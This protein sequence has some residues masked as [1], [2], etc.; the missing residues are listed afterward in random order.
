MELILIRHGEPDVAAIEACGFTGTGRNF[1]PLSERGIL[2]AEAV[3]HDSMLQGAALIVS[4]PYTRALQTAAVIAHS[5][6]LRI[7]V[8]PALHEWLP[9]LTMAH[10]YGDDAA[11]LRQDFFAHKG[12]CPKGETR[13]WETIE[14]MITRIRTVLDRYAET[15]DKLIVVAHGGV[16]RRLVGTAVIDYCTPYQVDYTPDFQYYAWVE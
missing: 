7:A 10:G 1:A 13:P 9:D 2:Q 15:H 4:S 11:D 12:V 16:L 14:A 3:A 6:G 8:E 5:T